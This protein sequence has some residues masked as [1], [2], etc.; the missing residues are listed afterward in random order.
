MQDSKLCLIVVLWG[1]IDSP[2]SMYLIHFLEHGGIC[3]LKTTQEEEEDEEE[4]ENQNLLCFVT[5]E[6]YKVQRG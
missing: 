3:A 6:L 4:E 2:F 1:N 5:T